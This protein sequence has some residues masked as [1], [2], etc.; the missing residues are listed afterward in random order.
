MVW[1][2]EADEVIRIG[3]PAGPLAMVNSKLT[4]RAGV[5]SAVRIVAGA[6]VRVLSWMPVA[7]SVQESS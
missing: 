5:A 2:V 4:D 1:R 6:P 3:L 7:R